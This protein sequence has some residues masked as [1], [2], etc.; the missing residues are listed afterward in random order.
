MACSI[1]IPFLSDVQSSRTSILR[2]EAFSFNAY[3]SWFSSL[4]RG[5]FC[6]PLNLGRFKFIAGLGIPMVGRHAGRD[7]D[8][9]FRGS[10]EAGTLGRGKVVQGGIDRIINAFPPHQSRTNPDTAVRGS[11]RGNFSAVVARS[12]WKWTGS[13]TRGYDRNRRGFQ[14]DP[15]QPRQ[16]A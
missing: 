6:C 12:R 1:F 7:L 3:F 9:Y 5:F 15:R 14:F 8:R 16:S 2:R 11:Q 4:H 10:W 13:G